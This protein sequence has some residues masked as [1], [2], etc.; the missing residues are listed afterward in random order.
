MP[1]ILITG[2]NGFLGKNLTNFLCSK[3]NYD[4]YGL[5]RKKNSN[6]GFSIKENLKIIDF[7]DKFSNL[8]SIVEDINPDIIIHTATYFHAE[9]T[10]QDILPMINGTYSFG[11]YLLESL[12]KKG[13]KFF[14]INTGTS[15]QHFNNSESYRATCLHSAHKEAFEKLLEYYSDVYGFGYTTLKLF[16][17]YGPNDKRKKIVNI[18]I[19]EIAKNNQVDLSPGEQLIDLVH[20]FDICEAYEKIINMYL[21]GVKIDSSYGLSSGEEIPLKEIASIIIN[22]LDPNYKKLNWGAR[23][24]RDREVM[25]NWRKNMNL[26][27]GWSPKIP[28]KS[29][30]IDVIKSRI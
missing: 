4:I 23:S 1:T 22:N 12:T 2:A 3:L 5:I 20:I 30:L 26:I 14:F 29:G 6:E 7:D 10:P 18:L 21:D 27:P 9:H 11:N 25:F 17:T 13:S 19:D 28:L 8:F 15:W 16:D 24:Y